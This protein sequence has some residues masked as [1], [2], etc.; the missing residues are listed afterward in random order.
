MKRKSILSQVCAAT[1]F[2]CSFFTMHAQ[3]EAVCGTTFGSEAEMYFNKMLPVIQQYEDEYNRLAV[4]RMSSTAIN[5]VPIKVHIIRRD[6]GSGGFFLNQL[7]SALAIMN[8]FYANAYI[9]FFL[10]EGVNYIDDTNLFDFETNEQD[11]MVDAYNVD[12]VVNIYFANT[13]TSSSSGSGLC[14]YAFFPGGPEVILMDNSCAANGSTLSHEMGHFFGLSHTHG[15]SNSTLTDELVDGSNC[16]TAGDRICDTPADPQ[17]SGSN[18]SPSC[19]Y[20]GNAIDANNDFFQPD[21]NNIM[22]YSRK[23]CR[24]VFSAGQYARIYAVYQASRAVMA[25]PSFNIDIAA[26]YERFCG[27]DLEVSFTDNSTGATSWEWDVDGD[28]VID[29]TT[30]NITHVY[31]NQNNYDVTLTI[32]DGTDTIT[33]VFQDYI[34]DGGEQINTTEVTLTLETDDWPAETSW[35]LKDSDGMTLYSSPVYV[36]GTDDFTVFTE[37][38]SLDLD[39]CYTFEISDSFGDGICCASGTG[40]FTLTTLEGQAFAF[41]GNF[42]RGTKVFMENAIA[43]SVD[44]FFS[45]NT[46]AIYPNPTNNTLNIK[47][48]DVNNLPE[49]FT[50]YNT[51]G[52]KI[53][54]NTINDISDLAIDVSAFN[55]G[56]YFIELSAGNSKETMRF[57]KN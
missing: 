2:L 38:F 56:L 5:S 29:Y 37:T 54:A 57:V 8:N 10:C 48:S 19:V 35:T 39:S 1:L 50:I 15:N 42:G 33:K 14:G 49:Q 31:S 16:S 4:S 9:E 26:D 22:S 13:V 30:P 40:S 53:M 12:N 43:L 41:G 11:A 3:E 18:V 55:D 25:C 20:T 44:D 45:E 52:Q 28:D 23:P 7:N 27:N 17:L 21:V 36:E 47:V 34:D 51:L 46:I 24:T 32:S 6:D